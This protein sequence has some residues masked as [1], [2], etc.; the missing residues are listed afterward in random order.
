MYPRCAW[1]TDSHIGRS[2]SDNEVIQQSIAGQRPTGIGNR[3]NSNQAACGAFLVAFTHTDPTLYVRLKDQRTYHERRSFSLARF[4][5]H[6]PFDFTMAHFPR[7]P[8][9]GVHVIIV[10]AGFAGI[11]AAIECE[12][13]GHSVV[14]FEKA[15][16][17]QDITRFGDIISFDPNGARNFERWPGVIEAMKKVARKTTWLDLYHWKGKFVTRQ[18]FANEREWGPRI[19]GHRGNCTVLFISMLLIGG[20]IFGGASV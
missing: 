17:V 7:R 9:S 11:A 5:T 3:Y 2:Q 12:R 4:S 10:G 19:N 8:P 15:A 20:W 13:K 18:N 6:R 16:D 1:T 14:V